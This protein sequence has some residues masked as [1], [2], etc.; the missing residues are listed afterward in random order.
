LTYFHSSTQH[1]G[2]YFE[3]KWFIPIYLLQEGQDK[4]KIQNLKPS[5]QAHFF[6]Q[7]S[8]TEGKEVSPLRGLV[9]CLFVLTA[10]FWPFIP[11]YSKH[12]RGPLPCTSHWISHGRHWREMEEWQKGEAAR[13]F[14]PTPSSEEH[15]LHGPISCQAT[16]AM[17]NFLTK[18]CCTLSSLCPYR[19][20]A[21]SG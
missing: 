13:E 19:S 6:L 1:S 7:L 15:F 5:I 20:K 17:E 8:T 9:I 16:P 4:T 11:S 14:V 18:F 21:C 3:I 12:H 10:I 2:R